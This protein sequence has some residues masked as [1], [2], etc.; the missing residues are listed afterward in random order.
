MFVNRAPELLTQITHFLS[1]F[2]RKSALRNI[3]LSKH[4]VKC[5]QCQFKL[6][7]AETYVQ[8]MQQK[9]SAAE[10]QQCQVDI[11]SRQSA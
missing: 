10:P 2:R 4:Q 7:N 9:R 3:L 5:Q 1:L 8:N 6:Q 11:A